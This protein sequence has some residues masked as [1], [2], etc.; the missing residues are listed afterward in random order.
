MS[1]AR[2][3]ILDALEQVLIAEGPALATIEHVAATAGVS[4]GGLLY[5]FGSKEALYEGLLARL[6]DAAEQVRVGTDVSAAVGE[7]LRQS[8][9]ADD[10]YSTTMLAAL[11]LV[12]APEVDVPA[13]LADAS[14]RW[15][16]PVGALIADPVTA[17]LVQLV[18][19]GLYLNA[20]VAGS[21]S[22]HDPAVVA[23]L[24]A[25]L[26]PAPAGEASGT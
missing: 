7:Y 22:E 10:A 12:G 5:H 24:L 11:R 19:D 13:A 6:T 16:A 8:S 20:L 18:G 23:R 26:E 4:K 15:F 9:V 2:H 1:T 14:D 3:R 17:R 25:S 21:A